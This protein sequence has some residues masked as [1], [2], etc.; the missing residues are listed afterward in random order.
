MPLFPVG[1]TPGW[2]VE[3]HVALQGASMLRCTS[4]S[5]QLLFLMLQAQESSTLMCM[6]SYQLDCFG[7]KGSG[8][9]PD[10]PGGLHSESSP[11]H[12]QGHAAANSCKWY[13]SS[14]ASC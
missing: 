2:W 6:G 8:W 1:S 4:E 9:A 13:L 12:T 3:Q 5:S 7:Q 10:L 11:A 14:G